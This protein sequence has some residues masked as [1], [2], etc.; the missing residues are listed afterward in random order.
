[1]SLIVVADQKITTCTIITTEASKFFSKVHSRMPV[2]L[3]P[4]DVDKWIDNSTAFTS[5][6]IKLLK[7]YKGELDW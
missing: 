2:I 4:E 7:P 6:V 5:E 3:D 1:M